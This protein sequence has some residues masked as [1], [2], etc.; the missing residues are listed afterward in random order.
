MADIKEVAQKVTKFFQNN[1][2]NILNFASIKCESPAYNKDWQRTGEL[3]SLLSLIKDFVSQNSIKGIKDLQIFQ[4]TKKTPALYFSV[5]PTQSSED[6]TILF[7]SHID[8]IPFGDGWTKCDPSDPKV[9]DGYLYGRGVAT[10]LYSIFTIV[11]MLKAMEELSINMPKI[12]VLLESSFESGSPDLTTY[13][14]KVNTLCPGISQIICLESWGPSNDHFHYVKST[15]GLISFDIKITTAL[16]GVHSGSFGGIIPDP[17][18]I[19]QN[20]LSS[21]IEKIEKS[22]DN[23]AT[24]VLI[25]SLEVDISDSQREECKKLCDE[26]GFNLISIIPYDGY[27]QLIGA[28]NESEDDDYLTAYINSVLRPSF[29]LLGFENMN[30]IENAGGQLKPYIQL[31]LAFR[32]PPSLDVNTGYELLKNQFLE[33][34]LFNAHIEIFNEELISGIDLEED[35]IIPEKM[36]NSF[37][38]FIQS[39]TGKKLQA[40]RL[41]RDLPCL[42]YLNGMFKDVPIVV[43]GAGNTFSGNV[44]EGNECLSIM[45]V[46]NFSTCLACFVSDY[47]NYKN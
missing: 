22:E 3:L 47:N 13:L 2:E 18:M 4:E 26:V 12:A 6:Y 19:F 15:R 43:T 7:Y 29:S 30:T 23:K 39:R 1:Q 32:T 27:T 8:K 11:S 38:G 41:C 28:K 33:N 20:I 44:R 14:Y 17:L 37:D 21:K 36:I 34:P 40:L 46:I 35:D 42:N 25:P 24:N 31:R 9:I 16:K 45:R 10:G 5:D